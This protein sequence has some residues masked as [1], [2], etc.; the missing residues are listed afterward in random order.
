MQT[1][2]AQILFVSWHQSNN[3]LNNSQVSEQYYF[4]DNFKHENTYSILNHGSHF[5][6]KFQLNSIPLFLLR[7]QVVA[8]EKS[9]R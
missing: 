8:G 2:C 7:Q 9:P 5:F 3:Y 4:L 6:K 1:L